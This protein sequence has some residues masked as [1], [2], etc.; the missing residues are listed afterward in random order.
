MPL[1]ELYRNRNGTNKKF[2]LVEEERLD[3][4]TKFENI[5]REEKEKLGEQCALV[6]SNVNTTARIPVPAVRLAVH[7]LCESEMRKAAQEITKL[8]EKWY[9]YYRKSGYNKTKLYFSES[10]LKS[11][12]VAERPAL[13]KQMKQTLN[14]WLLK[15]NRDTMEYEDDLSHLTEKYI[16]SQLRR[17]DYD[18]Y[19]ILATRYGVY[20]EEEF[21]KDSMPGERYYKSVQKAARM[22]QKLWSVYWPIKNM[23]MNRA[24]RL[25]QTLFRGYYAYKMWHPII[26]LRIRV[27]RTAVYKHMWKRWKEYIHLIKEIKSSL[28]YCLETYVSKC[29]ISWRD[30]V[31]MLTQ[32]NKELLNKF[33]RRLKNIQVAGLFIRW[34]M[35]AKKSIQTK[36]FARRIFQNPHFHWW[37]EYTNHMK[38]LKY[39]GK[40]ATRIQS[41][42]RG[43]I[44]KRAYQRF[45]NAIQILQGFNRIV[46]AKLEKLRRRKIILLK[47]YNEWLPEEL[48]A[49]ETRANEK[50]RRRLIWE[51][52][53]IQ[54]KENIL[55][56]DLKRHLHTSNGKFQLNE[57]AYKI[58]ENGILD[59]N[60]N[61]IS[62]IDK[63]TSLKLAQQQL[64]TQCS[65]IGR[66]VGKHDFNVRNPPL[67][68]CADNNCRAI[69][70]TTEQYFD[71][72]LKAPNHKGNEPQFA[73]F[74][75]RLKTQKF[76]ESIR[77]Y[78]IHEQGIGILVNRL[79]LWIAIQDWRKTSI[80]TEQFVY[81]AITIYETYLRDGCTRIIDMKFDHLKHIFNRFESVKYREYEGMY[82][83]TNGRITFFRKIFGMEGK[84]YEAWTTENMIYSD[85]FDEIEW[86]I[87][88]D[89]YYYF[90]KCGFYETDIG[91]EFLNEE[92]EAEKIKNDVLLK[93]FDEFRQRNILYW[94]KEFIKLE[95]KI[96]E[97]ADELVN[98]L[99][100]NEIINLWDDG[101]LIESN[102][103]TFLVM[104]EEQRIYEGTELM[105]EDVTYWTMENI[106]ENIYNTFVNTVIEGM[107]ENP[108]LRKQL[109][110]FA[111]Y[112]H[113]NPRSRLLINMKVK[114]EG[115][116]W[117][118]KFINKALEDDRNNLPLDPDKAVIRIQKRW[119]GVLGR[120]IVRKIFVKVYT[121]T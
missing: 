99:I 70:V 65:E 31:R 113:K 104:H 121:K 116:E 91:K 39:L 9:E 63:R 30:Y 21:F 33:V 7:N 81:K 71:H 95:N 107:W 67:H 120:N 20:S 87:F 89:L 50:E 83:I 53:I 75:L 13:M 68:R 24:A 58:R 98:I 59:E 11:T 78:L 6:I 102:Y 79:D 51:Q 109:L 57:I 15:K 48:N 88:L 117:F 16:N 74:H 73:K 28:K 26:K 54:E 45:C 77:Q 111:G 85:S 46:C 27:G 114:N 106:I 49:R 52:Q 86:L 101:A 38:H 93:L 18:R 34:N 62:S 92:M 112:L 43:F 103:A 35:F 72:M 32:H 36:L 84:Q 37:V 56:L 1:T 69:F 40:Y 100:G 17:R 47:E 97:K 42:I 96:S 19:F 66:L 64:L 108:E 8:N 110:E 14:E 94:T 61:K 76:Q 82:K 4:L 118:N 60:G 119:R 22:F 2:V 90:E 80:S 29:F 55:V 5:L 12:P 44:I 115:N 25:F 41:L 3:E 10:M 23:R 105:S